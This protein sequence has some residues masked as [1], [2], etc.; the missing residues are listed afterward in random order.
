LTIPLQSS[1]V[2]GPIQSRRLGNSL[3]IN[4][5]PLSW[6]FCDFH[7]VYCQYGDTPASGTEKVKRLAALKP[8]LEQEIKTAATSNVPVD[9]LT[10]AGNGEATLHPDFPEIVDAL[11]ELRNCY[12]PGARTGILTNGTRCYIPRVRDALL[13]LD[14][15]YVKVDAG[16]QDDLKRINRPVE[17]L[18]WNKWVE[19]IRNLRDKTVQSLFFSGDF[20]NTE[21]DQ[22][23]RWIALVHFL[24]P[25][26]VHLYSIDRGPAEKGTLKTGI[27]ELEK[28]AR[29]LE[30]E[31]GIHARVFA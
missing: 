19:G 29:R 17:T 8:V 27:E 1:I 14:D 10:V 20:G 21:D 9:C 5:L 24:Q 25:K 31:T 6:K 13:R 23:A 22:I 16:T 12:F 28:I 3:G 30:D 2:Y 7:C 11:T 18:C 4:I 15:R 26:A